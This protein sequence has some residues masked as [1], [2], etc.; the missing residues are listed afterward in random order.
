M[1]ETERRDLGVEA[2]AVGGDHLIAAAH[3]SGRGRDHAPARVFEFLAGLQDRLRA[4]HA[5]LL[6]GDVFNMDQIEAYMEL[7]WEEVYAFEHT[8][9]PIEFQMY[10]SV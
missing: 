5:F 6:K 2:I 8:P 3:R 10:Y 7:K 9:H 1:R 4:D